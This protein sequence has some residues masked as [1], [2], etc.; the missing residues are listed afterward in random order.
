MPKKHSCLK[1]GRTGGN[2]GWKGDN[3]LDCLRSIGYVAQAISSSRVHT[4]LLAASS[5]SGEELYDLCNRRRKLGGLG[6][7]KTYS[8]S[9]FSVAK[10]LCA[11]SACSAAA[12]VGSL[13]CSCNNS[14]NSGDRR[15]TAK[16]QKWFGP[17]LSL[18]LK[19]LCAREW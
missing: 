17:G 11:A 4:T 7:L 6:A 10:L 9:S 13:L 1:R 8:T 14:T 3:V 15:G 5:K 18:G 2:G 16:C 12:A 19:A